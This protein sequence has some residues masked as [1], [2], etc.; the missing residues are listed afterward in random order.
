MIET[1]LS[2]FHKLT[3][4]VMK[5]NFLNQVPKILSNRNYKYINNDLFRN[6]LMYEISKIG[7]NLIVRANNSTLMDNT[8]YKAIIV[9]R[10]NNSTFINNTIYKAIMVVRANNSTF[11][12]NTIYKAIM[13]RSRIRNKCL[14]LITIKSRLT[15]KKQRIYYSSL[16]RKA[17]R[18][19]YGNLDPNLIT[20]NRKF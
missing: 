11:I 10:A 7:R 16:I 8:I 9:V 6:E 1:G 4:S 12:N 18:N 19:F 2:D 14:K 20:D 3:V 17:K 5:A 15:Y 13:V